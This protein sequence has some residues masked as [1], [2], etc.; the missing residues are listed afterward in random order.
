MRITKLVHCLV[1]ALGGLLAIT[2]F[3]QS[4]QSES[5]APARVAAQYM[6]LMYGVPDAAID[7]R[8]VSG[9]WADVS[10]RS[11]AV[12]CDFKMHREP[13]KNPDGWVIKTP[14]CAKP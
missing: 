1:A 13:D 14:L 6:K 7:V 10:A 4:V 5:D 12:A 3:A 9:D 8:S 11:E 2:T